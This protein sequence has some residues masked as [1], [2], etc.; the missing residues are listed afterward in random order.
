MKK[1]KVHGYDVAILD[2]N[3]KIRVTFPNVK[4]RPPADFR[5]V[6]ITIYKYLENEGFLETVNN[7]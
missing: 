4:G 6:T 2:G 1:L 5:K 7:R 3:R